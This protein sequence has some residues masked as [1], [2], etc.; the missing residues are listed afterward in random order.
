MDGSRTCA[1]D[2][3]LKKALTHGLAIW[4]IVA[5][6][7]VLV[8]SALGGRFAL[9]FRHAFLP[10]AHAVLHGASPYSTVGS[11]ALAE[12]TA[13][14]YPPLSAYLLAPFTLLPPVVAEIIAVVLVAAAV[15]AALL[16]LGVRDWRCHAIAFLWWPTIIG[17]QSG[18]LTLPMLLGVALLWRYRD[19][20]VVAAVVA[21]LVVALKLFLWPLLLWFVATRR[22]RTAALAAAASAFFVLVP[23]A[24]IGFAGLRGY[25]HLLS[26]V[27]SSEGPRSYS[28]AALLHAMLPTWTAATAVET[29]FGVA[30][31]AVVLVAG[32][33]GRDR[34][35]FALSIVAI[36]V[37]SP[38]LEMHYLALL[39]IIV[40][41]YRRTFSLPWVVPLLI[42]GAPAT[43][44]GSTAQ[45]VHV[46]AVVAATVIVAL[47]DWRPQ[48]LARVLQTAH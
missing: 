15:P 21:G 32:R 24:G 30:L 14:L 13:Y 11:Q 3:P 23:W 6:L 1:Q 20:R 26:S 22:Y 39:L 37:L 10:A 38:L 16:V 31:L 40:A 19:R 5:P 46:L 35:A 43:V 12:G 34:D 9:D 27:S 7:W 25:P 4:A 18:N 41:L 2:D 42:W 47:W 36:L 48:A 8:T 28:V 33:R 17:I 29:L 45:V 44:A